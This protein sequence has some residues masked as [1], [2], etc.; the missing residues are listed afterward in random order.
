MILR[1]N[2]VIDIPLIVKNPSGKG[3]VVCPGLGRQVSDAEYNAYGATYVLVMGHNELRVCGLEYFSW[4]GASGITIDTKSAFQGALIHDIL[5]RAF[6]QHPD[7]FGQNLAEW[8]EW[9]DA[10]L[11]HQCVLCGMWRWRAKLWWL[12]VRRWGRSSATKPPVLEQRK[13]K[14]WREKLYK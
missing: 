8:R 5:Y 12:A 11:Y 3:N 7:V 14:L 2:C 6:R 10:V 9:A 4:D 1:E 13:I